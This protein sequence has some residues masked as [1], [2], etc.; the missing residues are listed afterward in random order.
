M[1]QKL[2]GLGAL[3]LLS[4]AILL[5]DGG[6][7]ISPEPII[8]PKPEYSDGGSKKQ[9]S[10]VEANDE[11]PQSGPYR[12]SA[13]NNSSGFAA[14]KKPAAPKADKYVTINNKQYPLRL[15]EPLAMPNDP[16]ASQ[17]WVANA[18][19]DQ[20]WDVPRGSGS[21]V[22]AII[23]TGFAL[24]H[25]EFSGR[26]HT[27][28]GE[29]GAA[30]SEQPTALN[31]TARGLALSASCNLIDDDRDGTVDNETG[32]ATYQNPSLLNCTAQS[33]PLS[34]DCNRIDDDGN[35]YIDDATGWDFINN[36]PSVQAG[37]LNPSGSG[38][39]HGTLVAGVAAATGNNGKGI[40]GVDW[41]TRIL[42]IQA[43]DDDGYGD[44]LSVGQAI[45]YA[46]GQ[47]ADVISLSLGS[48]YP[49]DYV[50][51]AVHAAAAAGIVVVAASGNGGCEC[52][53]YP[54]NYSE[55]VAVG[56][57]N[58]SS[59]RAS[60]SAWGPNLDLMAPGTSINSATWLP[61]NQTT[62]YASGVNG[63]SF[64]T[65]MVAGMFT[66]LLSHQPLATPL[67]L[68][69]ALGEN[70]NRL[71]LSPQ[72][73]RDNS[74]GYG[75]LDSAK[76]TARMTTGRNS[77]FLYVFT[78]LSKGDFLYP[79]QPSEV[80]GQY[81]AYSCESGTVPATP[82]YEVKKNGSHFFTI[83]PAEMS[84]ALDLSYQASI[85]GHACLQ[86]PQD[87]ASSVRGLDLFREFRNIYQ[88]P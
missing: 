42:P 4:I 81:Q 1:R 29:S 9:I 63:T 74:L 13:E 25:E 50:Q 6:Y 53:V 17:W 16:Q 71:G 43:L 77:S 20:M 26:W 31:C 48:V 83:S 45:F 49:D 52:M 28:A 41:G 54:A 78:P 76:A 23:D 87:T 86:Q 8:P 21:T 32:A 22:L 58:S 84:K 5:L 33:R 18:K 59:Q 57:L 72:T 73:P 30:S 55:V 69:A 67:Q 39:T 2:S 14:I 64:A 46:V 40:A 79:G 7:S 10:T 70:T 15:Y 44:T 56:A 24:G 60:F 51:E 47:G 12:V 88:R 62:A 19:L 27:N 37:Q 82:I 34:K 65:P 38:T 11:S 36:D 68:I 75:A 85:F 61:G 66:R 35:G 80:T 3:A